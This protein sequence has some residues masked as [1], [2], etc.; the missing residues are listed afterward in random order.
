MP[1]TANKVSFLIE[2]QI[3]DFINE[4]Y[5]LF[6]KFIQKYYE[7]NEIQG[8]P[9]DIISNLQQYRDI[10]FYEKNI[11][12][13]SSTT[14]T[15]VQDVDK[16]ITVVDATSFPKSGGYI[17]ID[18]EICFYK[19]R[20]DTEFLEVSRGVSGNTKIGDLYEKSTFV[21]TQADNHILGSTVQNI[22]NLFLYALIKSFE[23]QYLS[24]FPEQYLKK[25]IDKRTL[26]KNITSFYKAKGTVDS[27][28]FLF[29][30]LIDNDPE[31]SISYPREHTLKPSDS[32]WINNYSIKA[33]IL[34]GDVNDLIGRKITQ[35]TG[36]YA[37]AIVD[38]VRY[39]GQYD[40]DELY[41]LILSESSVNGVFSVST[42]TKLTKSV[43]ATLG[44]GDRVNVFSTMGWENKGK[45]IID[46]EVFTFSDKN[47]NQFII[48]SRTSNNTHDIGEIV[49]FGSDVSG[50]GVE[51]LVYGIVY[52]LEVDTKIPYSN[53]GDTIDISESGF[54]TDDIKIFDAQNNLRWTI[55]GSTP[56]IADLN[57]NVSAIYEDDDS[58]YIASSGFPSHAIGTLPSDAADQKHLKIIRKKPISTSEVY[59]T[60]S[61][62]VGIAING[63][64]FLSYKDDD[65][66]LN[67]PLQKITV[68]KRGNGY[69]KPP[70]VLIDGVANQA[71]TKLAGEVVESV[72]IVTAGEYTSVPTVEILSGR[73]AQVTPIVT[74]GEIT[75]ISIDNAGEY[76]SSPPEV[77]ISD[78]AGR[79]QFAVYTTE[80][81]TAGQLTNLVKVNGGKGYTS[82]NVLIDI[83]PVGS[84]A[85]ATATIKEWR[86]DRFKKTSV[87][88]ENGAFFYNYVT[89]VGQGY[90]YLASP[91]TLRTNDTG[92]SHSP[93]LGF[94]YDG[95]PIYGA[96]SYSDPLDSSSS[97]SK[98]SSSYMPVTTR[99]GGPTESNYPIGTFI[100]DWL[101]VHERGSLDKNNGRYCVTPEYPN[102]TYAYFITVDDTDTPVYPYVV[103]KSYYSL[104]VDSN[105]NSAL[106]QYDLPK[107]ARRLRTSDI[108]NNGDGT[109]LQIRDVTRGSIASAVIETSS[110]KFSVGSKL[111]IDESGTGGSGVD[112]EVDSVKGKSVVS[113]ES[114]TDKV[115]YLSLSDTAYLFDGDRVTQ[116]SATGRVVGNVFSATKFPIRSV[117]GTWSASGTLT[118]DTKVLTLLLDKNSSYTK[119]AI[120]SLGDGIA[121]PVAKG[122]VLETTSSQN[123]VKV[124]VTQEGFIISSEL[125][126]S[127]SDLLN[128][129]GSKIISIN[130]LSEN[131]DITTVQDNVALLTTA[132]NHG[133]AEGE[134]ITVDVNPNDST[135]TTTYEV[136]S[137]V[138]QEVT[139][140]IPVVATVLSDSGIGRFG[141]LNGGAD[142]TPDEYVDIALSGGTGSGARATIKVS[143][144]GVVNEITLT[145]RGTGYKK[146]DVLTVGDS[147]LVK[148]N[149]NT[150]SLKIEVDHAGFAKERTDLIVTSSLGFS[151]NDKLVIGNEVLTITGINS[152]T[153]TVDRGTKPSDHFDGASI[154]LQDAGFT[155]NSGYQ[156]NQE[157]VDASQPYVVSYD[158]VTQKVVFKYGYGITPTYLTLSSV[159]KDQ[160]TPVNRIVNISNVS[161]PI[162]C[163][164]IDGERN[165]IIDIKRY[166]KYIFNT[167]HSSMIGKKFDLSP[168]INHNLVAIEKDSPTIFETNIKVGFGS[169]IA[170]NTYTTKVDSPYNKYYYF[171]NNNIVDSESSYLNVIDDNLSDDKTVLY[172]TP[173]KILYS[174]ETPATHDGTGSMSY[175]TKSLF[176]VGEIDS[177]KVSNTGLNYK[178]LPIV[179][180]IIDSSGNVDTTVKCYL[181]SND[182][183]IPS[184]IKIINNGGSYHNDDSLK[185]TFRSNYVFTLSNF[186]Q[187]P[188]SVGETIIQKSGT[189]EVAR[190]RVTSWTEGSN[191][192]IVDRVTGI[193]RKDQNIIGLARHQTANLKNIS[194][195]EFSPIIQTNFDNI[196]FYSSDAGKVSDANQRIH[197]SYYYQDFSYTIKS[198]TSVDTW[199]QLIK[200]T[201]HPA[202]FQLFGEVL[203][204]SEVEA[205]MSDTPATSRVSVIQAWDPNKNRITVESVRKQITQNI[206]LMDNLNVQNGVG[207]VALD[208]LNTSEILGKDDIKLNASFNG[209]FG[210]K[211][212]R[213]GQKEFT[214]VDNNNN[215]VTPFN[216]QA[217]V[218]TLDGILQEPG[219]A[220]TVTNDKIT[221]AEAPLE[222]VSFYAKKF[223]FKSNNLST[224]YLK[225][226]RNIFQRNGRWLDASN[227]IERNKEFIQDSTL[228]HIKTVHPTLA[229]NSLSTKCFR[230]IG[231]IVDALAHDIRFGGNE[232]TKVS[233]EKYFNN[234]LLDYIDG[235]LEPTIEAFQY[236]VG[237]AKEAINNEL[238]GG[239]I[240]ND[241]LTDSGPVKCADVLAALD[242]LSEV[243]RVILTTGPGSVEVGYPDY[244]NGENTIFDL[245]YEDG[246]PV[247]TETN[248]DLWIALSGVLQVGD[249]Y[250][251]D[252][253]S[254]PNKIVFSKPPIWGQSKN[255]KTVYE[256]LAV[257]RFFGQGIGSYNKF[258]ISINSAGTGPFLIVDDNNDIKSIDNST[259]VFVFLDGVLQIENKS[260]TISGPSIRFMR[261]ISPKNNVHIISLYGRESETTLTLFDYERNQYYNE[262]KLTCDAGSPNDF[263]NWISWYN[264]SH[265]DHQVAYQKVGGVKKYIGNV[266]LYTTT[267]N[268]LIVTIAGSNQTLD[269]SNIFF[270]GKPD[271]S[272]EYELTGTTDTLVPVKDG[273]NENQMQR[274]SARWLYGT[275]RA[276]EAYF[277]RNRNGANL[278]DGDLIKIDGEEEWRTVNKL[279]RYTTPKNYNLDGDVS[280][281]FHGPVLVTKYSGDTYGT[282]L[283]VECTVTDGKVTAIT[284]NK[285]A[286]V[287][288]GYYSTPVLQFLPVNKQGGGAKAEVIVQ[289]GTVVDIV[290]TDAGSG[291]TTAPRVVVTRQFK[292]IKKNGRKIDS[293]IQL[294]F[295]NN[296][297]VNNLSV[298]CTI[299]PIRPIEGG[300]GGPGGPFPGFP[301]GPPD[302]PDDGDGSHKDYPWADASWTGKMIQITNVVNLKFIFPAPVALPQEIVRYWPTV[303]DSVTVPDMGNRTSLGISILELG[304]YK[305][306]VGFSTWIDVNGNRLPGDGS[307]D[308]PGGPGGP[309]DGNTPSSTTYQLG[310]VDHRF[311]N[312]AYNSAP[313]PL[314]NTTMRPAFF[315]WEGAKFMDTGDI[316]SPAGHSVSEYTIEE[317]DRYGF[318]LL[319][320][321]DYAGSGW[322]SSQYSMNVA[323]PTINNY[324]SQLDTTDLPDANGAGYV[325]TGA[326]VYANT[327]NFP[328]TGKILIGRETI[329]YTSKLSDRFVGCSRG[330]DGSPIE[331]HTVGAFL[332]NAN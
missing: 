224:K 242:T 107:S 69:K 88:S 317:F 169:R 186:N 257:E 326:V 278:I 199:R 57:S 162:T 319:E 98:M 236:A 142:Y 130:S 309:G 260:Y 231:F 219:K 77:R 128:T 253:S 124:K 160:S 159:F 122:E 250:S 324:L 283:S 167:S 91:T 40:G 54:V 70:F 118:S 312:P 166:Y 177:I 311:Y 262:L 240:D 106:N 200:E 223:Q 71:T 135:T 75:S 79:G 203:I 330:V 252:R 93:I 246:K 258:G 316:L 255:T 275:P 310:F 298:T 189:V 143:S 84:G 222:G 1:K 194:F 208:A 216:S 281:S 25:D 9:L 119:G 226:I 68:D 127:S 197:D 251:I 15:Y 38:N 315:Q 185:S 126:I 220:Y 87:D 178:K 228:T 284:W 103:G 110:D 51:L 215:A 26:I 232:K 12:K 20:T 4:E 171:D 21:T 328:A 100:Q 86:K 320:F 323:Y 306:Q 27:V 6:A 123:S 45:F 37:S 81:S 104:P 95:N 188:F 99:D 282:G 61:R 114:Q 83:I 303:V 151:V 64:P 264:L 307:P 163:F 155:L 218:V 247:D 172:V 157:T 141:I 43:G 321:S 134:K 297:L 76:Y 289:K 179:T 161:D 28:K 74:N 47:V 156:I 210:N 147:D 192:L 120:L 329:S 325:A 304:A 116:G 184:N 82:G 58:Y 164:E 35:T 292:V 52:N 287:V 89:S 125:F 295:E 229:W 22:S 259:F 276:D 140:E 272:D 265:N 233:L 60:G 139:V 5:E 237:L 261:P 271:F 290:I 48:E 3:P 213:I 280:N 327:T 59:D 36:D 225:K 42:K 314:H 33:K 11:L 18:D 286:G 291:Y 168:S 209:S 14:T 24:N 206:I 212:N 245:Y 173:T 146:Y 305:V 249:A 8:Q 94:A 201:T 31:P 111:V 279:P 78:L 65:V 331:S 277:E 299:T 235:E 294:G 181:S 23:K 238:T 234:G 85:I 204:E 308:W 13:Q 248:E 80:V 202:G 145:D 66:I 254:I 182:I 46:N 227:Q 73:N 266:K 32:T 241:I 49:T 137:A 113:I 191:I 221:F 29:K 17:K 318:Q 293:L 153:I 268:T 170:T 2:S 50:N 19:S 195:T 115:L 92:A 39:A 108:E 109:S 322:S 196:G 269:A 97:I 96:Y 230:D 129:P 56:A 30:C 152:N 131:L 214:L 44:T 55:G 198:K 288:E 138:Y 63:I 239:F 243:I 267:P 62:D 101:Y 149:A 148:T 10:D 270:A 190:A 217:L 132:S 273:F 121:L 187:K 180:G 302:L 34:S 53:S 211:G 117:T 285:D 67:G 154:T 90:G 256:G 207:S 193:F 165:K 144:A 150:A 300:P 158:A 174:T 136:K 301:G 263:I 102:G 205:K 105:Y 274:N 176:A 16:S 175:T 112:A 183:G 332:R 133:V 313:P 72:S 41:E 7:Q 244:F 296:I